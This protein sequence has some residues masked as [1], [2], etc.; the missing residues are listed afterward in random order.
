MMDFIEFD[1]R[2]WLV[3]GLLRL[4]SGKTVQML[5]EPTPN[6]RGVLKTSK[7]YG[8]VEHYTASLKAERAADYLKLPK[9]RASAHFIVGDE[10]EHILIQSVS[11]RHRAWHAGDGRLLGRNPND[12]TI[13][14]E[15]SNAGFLTLLNNGVFKTWYG[16]RI[17]ASRVIQAPD[18]KGTMKYWDDYD[19]ITLEISGMLHEGIRDWFQVEGVPFLDCWNHS[20][21]APHRKSDAGSAF[22]IEKMRAIMGDRSDEGAHDDPEPGHGLIELIRRI[23]G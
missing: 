7:G 13:G 20:D 15:H 11:L 4:P 9:A 8:I 18:H 17:P 6:R 21:A 1:Q 19:P 12:F 10:D 22:P 3:P 16:A 5:A 23:F 2:G 14:I